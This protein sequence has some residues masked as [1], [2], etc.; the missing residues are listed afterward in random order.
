MLA[1]MLDAQEL[2]NCSHFS[3]KFVHFLAKPI[4]SCHC[5]CIWQIVLVQWSAILCHFDVFIVT[6]THTL[7]S[8]LSVTATTLIVSP[9]SVC[10]HNFCKR[11]L[12]DFNNTLGCFWYYS[13]AV[14]NFIS[15]PKSLGFY[16]IYP[17]KWQHFFMIL[18]FEFANEN[19]YGK[20]VRTIPAPTYNEYFGHRFFDIGSTM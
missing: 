5:V 7:K 17:Q 18:S 16:R 14:W 15:S 1:N 13:L 10:K 11:A 4:S 8:L 19:V 20:S 3:W 12:S 9:V 2:C 6:Y